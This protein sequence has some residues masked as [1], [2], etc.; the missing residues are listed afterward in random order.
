MIGYL[1]LTFILICVLEPGMNP[2]GFTGR[3]AYAMVVVL[4][5][6]W[7]LAGR[8]RHSW[9]FLLL[10]G[11]GAI[12]LEPCYFE[13]DR[14]WDSEYTYSMKWSACVGWTLFVVAVALLTRMAA[15]IRWRLQRE[16]YADFSW[17][18]RRAVITAVAIGTPLLIVYTVVYYRSEQPAL[19]AL[20]IAHPDVESENDIPLE[21]QW[22]TGPATDFFAHNSLIDVTGPSVDDAKIEHLAALPRLHELHLN[23]TSV[24]GT[25]FAAL[26]GLPNLEDVYMP[27]SAINDAGMR[28]VVA[29]PHLLQLQLSGTKITDAGLENISRLPM[30]DALWLD[31]TAVT[32]KAVPFILSLKYL[33]CL[34]FSQTAL[35]N[36]GLMR[37]AVLT[38]LTCLGTK[39]TRVT[40]EGRK[41]FKALRPGVDLDFD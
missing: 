38:N 41:R 11:L 24:T 21:W 20:G 32:D 23:Q 33:H 28:F 39:D 15:K 37:L 17:I 5:G 8:S 9:L 6:A 22:A 19:A 1:F 36:E 26:T 30:L 2:P 16:N 27:D 7:H 3:G 18:W 40:D 10:G 4:L 14:G 12:L 35:S 13:N 34:S 29:L 25:G 31:R